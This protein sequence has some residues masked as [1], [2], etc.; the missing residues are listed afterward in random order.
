MFEFSRSVWHTCKGNHRRTDAHRWKPAGYTAVS[1]FGTENQLW[2][3][4]R[5]GETLLECNGILII[6]TITLMVCSVANCLRSCLEIRI[7]SCKRKSIK[8]VLFGNIQ[9]NSLKKIFSSN[10]AL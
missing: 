9:R 7:Q 4:A 2:V 8:V 3:G 5:E 1:L 10:L 6:P